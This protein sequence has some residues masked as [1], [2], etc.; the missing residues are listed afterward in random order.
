MKVSSSNFFSPS[1]LRLHSSCSFAR[2]N[3]PLEWR[4]GSRAA[5]RSP[6]CGLEARPRAASVHQAACAL[7]CG[8][9][10]TIF[11]LALTH[12]PSTTQRP[13]PVDCHRSPPPHQCEYCSNLVAFQPHRVGECSGK[14][15][16]TACSSPDEKYHCIL[17]LHLYLAPHRYRHMHNKTLDCSATWVSPG[18]LRSENR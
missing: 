15:S 11:A 14:R 17:Y 9:F 2:L 10:A 6:R 18:Y 7:L 5:S 4:G 8:P 3:M 12:S 1:R 13:S 16:A